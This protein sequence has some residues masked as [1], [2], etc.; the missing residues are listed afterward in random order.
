M[1]PHDCDDTS[2]DLTT[3]YLAPRCCSI[4]EDVGRLWCEDPQDPCPL[5]GAQWIRFD[6]ARPNRQLQRMTSTQEEE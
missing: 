3:I 4:E 2:P 6:R 5:C 1:R